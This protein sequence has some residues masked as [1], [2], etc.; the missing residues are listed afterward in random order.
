MISF[1]DALVIRKGDA[2]SKV[3]RKPIHTGLD[4]SFEYMYESPVQNVVL[5]L[6]SEV[7]AHASK[8]DMFSL[9]SHACDLK[10]S[11]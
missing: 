4:L 3:Y 6:Y 9:F 8:E 11:A 5:N 1:V 10:L 2:L 7:Y